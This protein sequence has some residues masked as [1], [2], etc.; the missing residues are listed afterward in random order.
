MAYDIQDFDELQ[1]YIT[2]GWREWY[3]PK[4]RIFMTVDGDYCNVYW[5]DTEKGSSGLTRLLALD[6]NDVTFGY[7]T[8]SS[9]GE[10]E[11]QINSYIVSAWTNIPIPPTPD[12]EDVLTAGNDGG[13]L[14]IANIA[15]GSALDS[16]ATVG[17]LRDIYFVQ[18]E[19]NFPDN[20][21]GYFSNHANDALTTATN[22]FIYPFYNCE[23]I[24]ADL[25]M[26]SYGTI[27]TGEDISIYIRVNNTTDYLI[28]TV[29][30]TNRA[31]RFVNTGL[32]ITLTTSDYFACKIVCPT[33][34]TN[35]TLSRI[36]GNILTKRT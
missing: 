22:E 11:I 4:F 28:A 17:Q 21:V 35:P 27:G 20:H 23:I 30:N 12:L 6:Y 31:K 7:L 25:S 33:W 36:A 34:A 26:V 16:A 14:E 24:A 13:G 5:T 1:I 18:G 2:D 19:G 15:D 32:S 29:G 8:P 10:V 3:I 9:A